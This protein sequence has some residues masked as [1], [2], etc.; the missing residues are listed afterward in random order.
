MERWKNVTMY[1]TTMLKQHE[2]RQLLRT[3]DFSNETKEAMAEILLPFVVPKVVKINEALQTEEAKGAAE[4]LASYASGHLCNSKQMEDFITENGLDIIGANHVLF[5]TLG[6]P[7]KKN[8]VLCK[9]RTLELLE[10]ASQ[11]K[12]A[13]IIMRPYKA[14]VSEFAQKWDNFRTRKK[15]E[16]ESPTP[17]EPE[18]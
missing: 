11:G 1:M 9:E 5:W 18:V 8:H 14:L 12:W 3:L 13:S 7:P 4:I 2:F 10:A 15:A 16:K 6:C 17:Q